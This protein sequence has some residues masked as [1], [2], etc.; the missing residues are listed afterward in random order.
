MTLA[1]IVLAVYSIVPN[2]PLATIARQSESQA[3]SGSSIQAIPEKRDQ[4][5]AP[6]QQTAPVQTTPLPST[7][8]QAPAAKQHSKRRSR[9]KKSVQASNCVTSAAPATEASS[10]ASPTD[11]SAGSSGNTSQTSG[12]TTTNCPPT[13][14]IVRQGG[15]KEPSIQLAGGPTPDQAAKQRQTVNQLL[16]ITEA[17]LKKA[18]AQQLSPNQQE[19]LAQSR[20]FVQ[21]S[22][23]AIGSGDLDRAHNL[24][25]KAE[26]LSE[27]LI[28]PQK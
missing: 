19:T 17:N 3:G 12:N 1:L 27:D 28:K 11:P 9:K 24:A 10:S 8:T 6:Q 20:A 22:R 21:Q 26:L 15:T 7:A 25:W 5:A 13:K 23:E 18:A 16:G 14:V 2:S 4:P